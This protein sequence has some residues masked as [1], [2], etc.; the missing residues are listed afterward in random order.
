MILSTKFK[1]TPD[2]TLVANV[3][4]QEGDLVMTN[5]QV[6][7]VH[8][9]FCAIDIVD[10][11]ERFGFIIPISTFRDEYGSGSRNDCTLDQA[12]EK[13]LHLSLTDD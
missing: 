13:F 8:I 6:E 3:D 5:Q 7:N 10:K 4:I 9:P 11:M 1:V 12:F 2:G